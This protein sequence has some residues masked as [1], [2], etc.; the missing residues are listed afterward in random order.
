MAQKHIFK[1]QRPLNRVGPLLIYRKNRKSQPTFIQPT[2]LGYHD[3]LSAMDGD[4]KA[5]FPG[6]MKDGALHLELALKLKDHPLW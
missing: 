6:Y 5:Y 3:V 4:V 2:E 1:V